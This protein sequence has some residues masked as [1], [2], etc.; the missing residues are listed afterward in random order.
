MRPTFN[1][2]PKIMQILDMLN[3]LRQVFKD[4]IVSAVMERLTF[5][6]SDIYFLI[7]LIKLHLTKFK[8]HIL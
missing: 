7:Y 5:G 1:M 3:F 6:T 2:G 8:I 4:N